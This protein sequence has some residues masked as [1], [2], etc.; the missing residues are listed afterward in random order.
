MCVLSFSQEHDAGAAIVE[1]GKI[2]AAIN[3]ERLTRVKGQSG[4]PFK[5]IAEVLRLSGKSARDVKHVIVP[6]ISKFV[7]V[8]KNVSK[9]PFTAFPVGKGG[10]TS[11][12]DVLRHFIYSTYIILQTYPR[13]II[14]HFLDVRRLRQMF[15]RA[16]FHRV[17]HHVC[18]AASAF[19]TS[20]YDKALIITSDYWGDFVCNMVA[21]GEG[22]SIKVVARTWYPNSL[23]HYY[24]NLTAWLGFRPNRHEGKILGLAAFG[25]AN[26]PAYDEVK[27]LIKVDGLQMYCPYMIGK[28]WHKK[29][30]FFKKSLMRRLQETYSREDISAVFQRRFE[31]AFVDLAKNAYAKFKI[32]NLVLAGGTFSN[33]KLNQRLFEIPG[34]KRIFIFPNMTDGGISAGAAL[35]YDISTNGSLGSALDHVYFGPEYSNAE[36]E[37]ALKRENVQ[38]EYVENIEARMAQLLA[39][40]KVVAR[41]NGKMEYGPR[42]LGNRSILYAATDPT[43]NDWLNK[44]LKR[45][46]FMPFAPVT[47]AEFA[48][49]CYKN[50]HGAEYPAK[51]MTITFDC[52]D[53]MKQASPATVHVDGT[54]RPQLIDEKTNPSY[55]RVLKEYH[56]IT[57]I[58]TLV[59]TSFNMHEEP[60]VCSPEDA[61]RS[62]QCGH[63]GY[64]AIGNFL[65]GNSE[66]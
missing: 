8:V 12:L 42:A 60:I 17:E 6:E 38:Y 13:V 11:V 49:K 45:T 7:D 66:D 46:E 34:M 51:F 54:A 15:P 18:H 10:K 19:H 64:L 16:Q 28:M 53:Y 24:A 31:E 33:V 43:V 25:N 48:E 22:K 23:G 62:Y 35:H 29:F 26:S 5:S 37:E 9:Y 39:D 58:P 40:N 32:E 65:V 30:P 57:G 47:M 50:L 52:T 41:F 1:K 36:I 56:K 63:L 61:I 14:Q 2:L 59:N 4:F 3:E 20:G 55:Y 27:D 44:R 21:V